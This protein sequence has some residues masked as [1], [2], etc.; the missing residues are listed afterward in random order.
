MEE[1]IISDLKPV[2]SHIILH[3][4]CG[5]PLAAN[6]LSRTIHFWF[7]PVEGLGG[8]YFS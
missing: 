8:G 7:G 5:C 3:G 2:T 1:L 4:S 6:I